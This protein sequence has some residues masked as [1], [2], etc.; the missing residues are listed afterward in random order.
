[1]FT[2]EQL[3]R[4]VKDYVFGKLAFDE[5]ED[6]FELNSGDAYAFPGLL[7]VYKEVDAALS[8]YHFDSIGEA[9]LRSRLLRLVELLGAPRVVARNSVS[10]AFVSRDREMLRSIS[11]SYPELLQL[12]A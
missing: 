3:E 5:F 1:M 4:H 8:E 11:S 12:T 9:A 6:W 10:P 2:N 7:A